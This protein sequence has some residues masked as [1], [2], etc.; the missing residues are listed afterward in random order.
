VKC[1]D[2]LRAQIRGYPTIKAFY[3]GK[4]LSTHQAR[5]AQARTGR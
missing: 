2:A 3:N 4:E 1:A 5:R